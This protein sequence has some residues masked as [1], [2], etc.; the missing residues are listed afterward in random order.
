MSGYLL[1][2]FTGSFQFQ[3]PDVKV[4]ECLQEN[5]FLADGALF[6]CMRYVFGI[7]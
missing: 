5:A 3:Y 2:D 6:Q 4:N 7:G 1:N